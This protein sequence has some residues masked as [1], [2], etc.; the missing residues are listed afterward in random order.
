[1]LTSPAAVR[2]IRRELANAADE[3]VLRVVALLDQQA[4][5]EAAHAVLDPVRPRLAQ[6]NPPRPLRFARLL[7]LPLD[8]LV[9][10]ARDWRPGEAMIP[11][12]VL[13]AIGRTVHAALRPAV[14]EVDHM[15]AGRDTSALDTIAEAGDWLWPRAAEVLTAAPAPVGWAST[16]LPLSLYPALS[17]AIAAVLAQAR[18]LTDL[19]R[20]GDPL[21]C[22]TC[23]DV[24]RDMLIE[25][26][27]ASPE[28]HDMLIALLLLQVPHATVHLRALAVAKSGAADPIVARQS[29]ERGLNTVLLRMED[30]AG[31]TAEVRHAPLREVR[32]TVKRVLNL[33]GDLE[34]DPDAAKYRPRLHA[35]KTTLDQACRER[36]AA[37]LTDGLRTPLRTAPQPIDR[38][39]QTRFEA[40]ART[41][42]AL[43]AEVRPLGG[44]RAYD[45]LMREALD[46]VMAA[47]ASGILTPLRHMRLVEIL[48]GP[49]AAEAVG[50]P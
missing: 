45:T 34:A 19:V 25:T 32:Q 16:G 3:Q 22:A 31:L 30:D 39:T 5:P 9:V 41:L 14:S 33:A 37:S 24:L 48:A 17:K 12:G 43:Q 47:R 46:A 18:P 36:F 10:P 49:D 42:R 11:R 44:G 6:L 7:F 13:H 15:I 23:H 50:R 35:I 4:V 40:Q 1:M 28:G 8:P 38:D 29:I 27:A 2:S 26:G 20:D 21:G